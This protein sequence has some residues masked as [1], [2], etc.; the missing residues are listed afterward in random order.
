M[1][2]PSA[3]NQPYRKPLWMR[4]VKHVSSALILVSGLYFSINALFNLPQETNAKQVQT[5]QKN[6]FKMALT[7]AS[8]AVEQKWRQNFG[9]DSTQRNQVPKLTA[10]Q[11]QIWQDLLMVLAEANEGCKLRAERAF[12]MAEQEEDPDA[13]VLGYKLCQ[14][15]VRQK[16]VFLQRSLT[17]PTSDSLQLPNVKL[18][19]E[20]NL[21]Q[22]GVSS[23]IWPAV[24]IFAT[25]DTAKEY[26]KQTVTRW[27][28]FDK[29]LAPSTALILGLM[30]FSWLGAAIG[31]LQI[32]RMME[33][34]E[35]E[36]YTDYVFL[37]LRGMAAA[38]LLY[39]TMKGGVTILTTGSMSEVNPYLV[40]AV[41]FV[42][43]V[44]SER[45]WA[46]A[47]DRFFGTPSAAK[48]ED[49]AKDLANPAEAN[50]RLPDENKPA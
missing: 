23:L 50:P 44:F 10:D 31:R 25:A 19:E 37:Y 17:T 14:A 30:G 41:S 36:S 4:A 29:Q 13:Y 12:L 34:R 43:A 38:F 45:T 35:A 32:L 24:A 42:G 3:L 11:K 18:I 8:Q 39:L 7:E 5:D 40:L 46:W 27:L 48:T 28:W 20:V 21:I 15:Q 22:H 1:N 47:L 49:E 26:Q 16:A 33:D 9:Q 2:A 6:V